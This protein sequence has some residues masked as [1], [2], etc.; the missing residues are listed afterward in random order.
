MGGDIKVKGS[1]ATEHTISSDTIGTNQTQ[2]V[3]TQLGDAGE[4]GGFVSNHNPMPVEMAGFF[5]RLFLVFG[6]FSFGTS[7]ALRTEISNTPSVSISGTPT[8]NVT[9]GNIGFGDTGKASTV[10][11]ITQQAFM[12]GIRQNFTKA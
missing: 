9:T 4:D 11:Q 6:R 8:M 12:T 5:K 3:K 10:Q 7:S 1:D 2:V